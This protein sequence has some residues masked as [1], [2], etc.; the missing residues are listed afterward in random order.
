[1]SEDLKNPFV[2]LT[3][4][5]QTM[6]AWTK[7][8]ESYE[9]IPASYASFFEAQHQANQPLPYLVLTPPLDKAQFKSTEKLLYE[10]NEALWILERVGSQVVAKSYPYQTLQRLEMGNVLLYSWLTLRGLT[11]EGLAS[12]TTI[13]YNPAVGEQHL[14]VFIKKLR[15]NLPPTDEAEFSAE[16]NKFNPLSTLNFKLMNFGRSSLVR[17]AKVIQILFQPEIRTTRWKFLNWTFSRLI[18]PAHLA[19]LTD[20]EIILIQDKP[21]TKELPGG[22]YG[23]V[24]Q[25]LRLNSLAAVS[26]AETGEQ[27]V[28]LRLELTSNETL[29]KIFAASSQPELEQFVSQLQAML[30]AV[31]ETR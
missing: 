20:R 1:M 12:S 18:T 30:G 21:S 25:Y 7:V 19:I 23:G 31:E 11:S 27:R 24:W 17:G 29:E 6:S 9:A 15:P 26:L 8:I 2:S 5:R 13:E 22:K 4:A 10:A 3:G 28:T 16:K 14:E